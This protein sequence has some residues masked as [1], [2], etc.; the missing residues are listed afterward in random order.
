MFSG[1]A[2]SVPRASRDSRRAQPFAPVRRVPPT[3]AARRDGRPTRPDV[4]RPAV[5]SICASLDYRQ[6]YAS[7]QERVTSSGRL[8]GET[9]IHRFDSAAFRSPPTS[10]PDPKADRVER[11]GFRYIPGHERSR[12]GL[13]ARIRDTMRSEG[14]PD[15][16]SSPG[17]PSGPFS[18]GFRRVNARTADVDPGPEF[19][20]APGR[21]LSHWLGPW[22][23][24]RG[25]PRGASTFRGP[26]RSAGHAWHW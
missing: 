15:S 22:L 17:S 21:G 16:H 8:I 11:R 23:G 20:P 26:R 14:G 7:R 10:R 13:E 2:A 9:S 1:A 18:L 19:V 25:G 3:T 5:G 4:C 6:A 12:L 24:G